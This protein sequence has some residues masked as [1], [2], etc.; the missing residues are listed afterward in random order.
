MLPISPNEMPQTRAERGV[1]INGTFALFI[2]LDIV[3]SLLNAIDAHFELSATDFRKDEDAR[4]E[5]LLGYEEMLAELF[6]ARHLLSECIDYINVL[7]G[8][9]DITTEMYDK[10]AEC[11]AILKSKGEG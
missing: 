11:R 3:N 10:A 1:L 7:Q 6:S 9:S 4:N 5:F 2:H 8:T